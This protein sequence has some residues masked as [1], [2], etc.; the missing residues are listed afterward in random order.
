[1]K[2]RRRQRVVFRF[3]NRIPFG[4][5][6]PENRNLP[7]E[8]SANLE[9]INFDHKRNLDKTTIARL[10]DC[11]WIKEG[12]N[13]IITGAAGTGKT[14]LVSAFGNAACR[15][16]LKVHS[17]RVNRLLTD[18]AISRGDGSYN[19]LLNDLKK[20]DLLILD[21]FGMAPIDPGACRDLLE[22][23]DDRHGRKSIA[24]STQL[25]VAKWH[26]VFEDATIAD[27]VLDRVVNNA[28]RIELKGPSLR[29]HIP[30]NEGDNSTTE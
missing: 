22:V 17:Y 12:K 24:I 15:K 30:Q 16:S 2:W 23:I 27:A 9:N 13:L 4:V 19:R 26:A 20:P 8:P 21:D 14:Y 3:R 1:M 6:T 11:S 10:A 29:P 7:K 5:L 28:Y 18:L 25:P